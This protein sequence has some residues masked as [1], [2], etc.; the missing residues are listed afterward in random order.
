MKCWPF[1]LSVRE[2]V[3]RTTTVIQSAVKLR[4]RLL[5]LEYQAA[6]KLASTSYNP[7]RVTSSTMHVHS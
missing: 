2:A 6:C 1:R 5:H 3:D 7:V 4:P